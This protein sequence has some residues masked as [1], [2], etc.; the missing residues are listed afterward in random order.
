MKLGELYY[1][2]N[3]LFNSKI[4]NSTEHVL[5]QVP[6]TYSAAVVVVKW[7]MGITDINTG[8]RNNW[9]QVDVWW[10]GSW[11]SEENSSFA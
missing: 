7:D 6:N 10:K 2:E 11:Y 5:K 8:C 1:M 9:F 4:L 3:Y